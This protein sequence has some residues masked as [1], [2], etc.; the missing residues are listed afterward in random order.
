MA[1][2]CAAVLRQPNEDCLSSHTHTHSFIHLSWILAFTNTHSAFILHWIQSH[3]SQEMLMNFGN[4]GTHGALVFQISFLYV[5]QKWEEKINLKKFW[6][7]WET[8]LSGSFSLHVKFLVGAVKCFLTSEQSKL[9]VLVR[10][11]SEVGDKLLRLSSSVMMRYIVPNS[12]WLVWW[13]SEENCICWNHTS[14]LSLL[15]IMLIFDT[16]SHTWAFLELFFIFS[17]FCSSF[18]RPDMSEKSSWQFPL[19]RESLPGMS[20]LHSIARHTHFFIC[21]LVSTLILS[22]PL[23][24][25][26]VNGRQDRV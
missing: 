16:E 11:E 5:P 6:Q 17:L 21:F 13:G 7:L 14:C 25:F 20:A 8:I 18:Y 19:P 26:W 24:V 23:F 10:W 22:C 4:H 2:C 15:H 9:F 12:K 3:N 1:D